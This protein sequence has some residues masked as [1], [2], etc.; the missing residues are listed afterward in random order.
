MNKTE[1]SKKAIESGAHASGIV[2]VSDIRFS[3]DFR[4]ACEQNYCGHY[5]KN[6]VCPPAVGP[7]VELIAQVKRY[8]TGVVVQTIYQ[9]EDSFDI[10]G[11][12]EAKKIHDT[13]YRTVH[14]Y[15]LDHNST[16]EDI[17]PLNAGEC[18]L[19]PSCTYPE[20]LPCKFPDKAVSSL[21]AYGIDV[22]EL[23]TSCGLKYNNGL[24][25]VSYT[26]MFLFS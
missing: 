25:T 15:I 14:Q 5:G 8:T 9:L 6:W 20:G 24:H 12:N 26:G 10:D 21:E 17:L 23:V 18:N 7:I 16:Q 4:A 13:M 11:M 3:E 1:L 2:T 22:N 19:C